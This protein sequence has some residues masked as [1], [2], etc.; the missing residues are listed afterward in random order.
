MTNNIIFQ[1]MNLFKNVYLNPIKYFGVTPKL[2]KS[3][4][5][6]MDFKEL[7]ESE[8]CFKS[9][10]VSVQHNNIYF[11]VSIKP[12]DYSSR[13]EIINYELEIIKKYPKKNF[14]FKIIENSKEDLLRIPDNGIKV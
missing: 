12:N 3:F 1:D 11:W 7:L 5:A 14:S 10:F 9:L 8:P 2:F 13:D 4:S 6:I